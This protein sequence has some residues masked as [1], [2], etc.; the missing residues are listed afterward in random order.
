MFLEGEW[1]V[2]VDAE[3]AHAEWPSLPAQG[4]RSHGPNQ[5]ARGPGAGSRAGDFTQ[6]GVSSPY[7]RPTGL[8]LRPR[9][10]SL[11]WVSLCPHGDTRSLLYVNPSGNRSPG[12][13]PPH[14]SYKLQLPCCTR[15]A[16]PTPPRRTCAAA[17][18]M[19]WL[20]WCITSQSTSSC[21][22]GAEHE[23][24]TG[25]DDILRDINS[26]KGCARIGAKAR[27]W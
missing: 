26:T 19:R 21:S 3:C 15:T 1:D 27:L 22:A 9:R 10:P 8:H 24:A 17:S 13:A 23:R 4:L 20:A 18:R 12:P 11:R 2:A 5:T 7:K 6:W 14:P 16:Q 25:V